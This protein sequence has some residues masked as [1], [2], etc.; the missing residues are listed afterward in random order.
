MSKIIKWVSLTEF[1][2]RAGVCLNTFKDNYLWQLPE[3]QR[4]NGN[5]KNWTEQTVLE[6]LNKIQSGEIVGMT[7][8]DARIESEMADLEV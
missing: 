7:E 5:R 2:K 6:V 1:A 4:V 8:E 3:P